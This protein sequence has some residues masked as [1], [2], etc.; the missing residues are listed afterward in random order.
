M[1][2][3]FTALFLLFF[4]FGLF[5]QTAK[6]EPLRAVLQR[7]EQQHEVRFA[8]L[9]SDVERF[10]ITPPPDGSLQQKLDHISQLTGLAFAFSGS[11]RI[12]VTKP[13]ADAQTL[14]DTL[15]GQLKEVVVHHYLAKGITKNSDAS[16]RISPQN[17]GLLPGLI[18]ADV[19]QTMQQI[20]GILSVD[21]TISNINVRGGTHDQNLFLW[22]GIRMFQTGHFFGLVSAFSPQLPQ[23]IDVYKNGTPSV[24]GEGVSSTVSIATR[25]VDSTRIGLAANMISAEAFAQFRIG[26]TAGLSVSARRSLTDWTDSPTY[27]SYSDRIFQ[28]TKVTDLERFENIDYAVDSDFHF[29][30]FSVQYVQ[31]VGKKSRFS[32]AGIGIFNGLDIT[33]TKFDSLEAQSR[34]SRLDQR[35]LG[36]SLE[37]TTRWNHRNIT[38]ATAY[39]SNY[40]LSA[41]NRSVENNQQVDQENEVLD[42]GLGIR[43]VFRI[44]DNL[45]F[46]NAYQYNETGILNTDLVNEPEYG[47]RTKTVLRNHGLSTQLDYRSADGNFSLTPG[48]RFNYYDRFGKFRLEPR[49]RSYYRITDA[50]RIEALAEFKSQTASQIIDLQQDFLGL[51][52]RRWVASDDDDVPIQ[53]SFQSSLGA[54]YECENWL[55]NVDLFYKNVDGIPS[56]SQSFQNQLEFMRINGD[57]KIWGFEALVQKT[58]AAHFRTWIAYSFNRNEYTFD[59][60]TP[61]NFANNFEIVHALTGALSYEAKRFK[62][63]V[64]GRWYTGKPQTQPLAGQ[65]IPN[66]GQIAYADPNSS[67]LDDYFQSNVS[68]SYQIRIGKSSMAAG[69]S[70]MN[71]LDNRN[72]INRYYRLNDENSIERVNTYALGRTVNLSLKVMF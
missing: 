40:D 11:S 49:L 70:V 47:R 34:K 59:G 50:F 65:T 46:E 4:S 15:T 31:A 30:D 26:K 67:N 61:P 72:V 5:A 69:F 68:C 45:T 44:S 42:T 19:L 28:N 71:L 56:A 22:N 33:Q 41:T 27:R 43:H 24:F 25:A 21:E 38:T 8:F 36:S 57:Y 14:S 13:D 9:D 7:L 6:P 10:E 17:F 64:G 53:R 20:P 48:L 12:V 37:W 35:N 16:L 3:I 66:F 23:R 32:I 2:K 1:N 54:V 51:E 39:F 60:F 63:S 62:A 18:E 29:Y 58:F 55:L 52:K